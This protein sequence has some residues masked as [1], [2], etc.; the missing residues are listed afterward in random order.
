VIV[1]ATAILYCGRDVLL[2][3][4][5][6]LILAVV[7]SPLASLLEPYVGRVLG[8]VL[9][10]LFSIA[11]I[12]V[13]VY[14]LTIELTAVA[15]KVA[16]YSALTSGISWQG[17]KQPHLPGFDIL[18]KLFPIYNAGLT[19]TMPHHDYPRLFRRYLLLQAY[20]KI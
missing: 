8:A 20:S 7:F 3:I 16:E 4:T 11:V 19:R 15:D 2:P 10:V 5:M 17:C 18:N 9:V 14:F 6:A 13:V 1:C 12:G